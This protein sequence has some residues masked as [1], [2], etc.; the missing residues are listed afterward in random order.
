MKNGIA[1]KAISKELN[2]YASEHRT[3]DYYQQT[4]P[5]AFDLRLDEVVKQFIAAGS[6]DRETFQSS[7]TPAARSQFGIYGHRAA[8]RAMREN[9]QDYVQNGLVGAVIANYFVP[10]KRRVE[11]GLAIYYHTAA[12]LGVNPL[13]LFTLAAGY[14][15]D[16][17]AAQL[18]AF[19]N[20]ADVSLKKQGWK[21]ID[22][23]DGVLYKFNWK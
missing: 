12:K 4:I 2:Q 19:G 17:L 22:A 18:V 9:N 15:T 16:Y 1:L 20:R 21:E 23:P 14:A 10:D 7:L 13:D 8:T 11:T 3:L 6:A 5:S